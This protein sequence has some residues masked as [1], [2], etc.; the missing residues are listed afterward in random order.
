MLK[1]T[2]FLMAWFLVGTSE[3]NGE[4]DYGLHWSADVGL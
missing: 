2:P 3:P 1:S 4:W